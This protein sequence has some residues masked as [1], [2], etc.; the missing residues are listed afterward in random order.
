M[1]VGHRVITVRRKITA[2]QLHG[3]RPDRL[4]ELCLKIIRLEAACARGEALTRSAQRFS[5]KLNDSAQRRIAP[6]G[7]TSA[8]N[9]FD[10]S[11]RFARNFAP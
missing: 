9:D 8:W 5:E 3:A 10:S 11:E 7:A 2:E 4:R 1:F 6:R